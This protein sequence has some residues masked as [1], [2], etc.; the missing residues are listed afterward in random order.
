MVLKQIELLN[1]RLHKHTSLDFSDKLNLIVG[2]NG[3]G[4]TSILEAIY[5]LC[6]TKNLNLASENDVVMFGEQFFEAKGRFLDLTQNQS[7][8][9]YDL[10][11]NKKN[12][13]LDDKQIYNSSSII[14]KFPIV[15]LIQSDHAI[16]QGSPAERRRF[17]DSVISQASHAYLEI[18]LEYNK[19]L[20]QRSALLSQI[21]ESRNINLFSQLEAWTEALIISGTEIIKHRIRFIKEFNQYLSQAYNHIVESI[22]RPSINYSSISGIQE[23]NTAE[24]FREELSVLREDELR[25]GTNLVG[26]HRDDFILSINGL[27]L[28]RFGS[29]GQHKTFQIALRFGQ[30]FFIKEK[31]G[32]TPIFLMDDIFGELDSYRAGKI[33]GYLAEIGQAFITMTDL[34]KTESLNISA[35]NILIKVNNGTAAYA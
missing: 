12:F 15:S 35:E 1:F 10:P 18:L 19:T 34:T 8:L 22:E 21:K 20:R 9:L 2:G 29:Q 26:P 24:K 23:T 32:R 16:T 25:R 33:S 6:T 3:Q 4:K 13:F 5:Y 17:V 30:F 28:K 11:K 31:L 14:G 7:R 27:E